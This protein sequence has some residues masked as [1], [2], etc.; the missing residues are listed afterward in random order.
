MLLRWLAFVVTI[1]GFTAYAEV[2]DCRDITVHVQHREL[3]GAVFAAYAEREAGE[4]LAT[5]GVHVTWTTA[6]TDRSKHPCGPP[7]VVRFALD[8][9]SASNPRA[10]AYARPFDQDASEITVFWEKL[11]KISARYMCPLG[12]LLAHVLAHEIVHILQARDYHAG[13]GLMRSSWTARD[14]FQMMRGHLPFTQ[15]DIQLVREGIEFRAASGVQ[16][17]AAVNST[18][19]Q[20]PVHLEGEPWER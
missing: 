7:I 20:L 11:G 10:F 8:D 16:R 13:T 12:N 2:S 3:P 15:T 5:A 19:A 9:H 18:T 17:V 6:T 4:M 14:Y 1:T